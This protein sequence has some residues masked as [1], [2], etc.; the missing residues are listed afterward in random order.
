MADQQQEMYDE[1]NVLVASLARAFKIEGKDAAKALE[2]GDMLLNLGVDKDGDRFVEAHYKG[3]VAFVYP[4][5]AKADITPE[6][7]SVEGAP[8]GDA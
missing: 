7:T 2:G 6:V 8:D 1:I 4:G 3:A 5:G